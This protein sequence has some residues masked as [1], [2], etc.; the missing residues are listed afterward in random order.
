MQMRNKIKLSLI[1]GVI[2]L[3][4]ASLYIINNRNN[5]GELKKSV[6]VIY[7][8][9]FQT[10]FWKEVTKGID[11]AAEETGTE[12]VIVAA[13]SEGDVKGQ[14]ALVEEGIRS[15][16]SAILLAATDYNKLSSVVEEATDSDIPVIMIDSGVSTT[17]YVSYVGTDNYKAGYKVGQR[18]AKNLGVGD[19]VMIMNYIKGAQSA[20]E[21]EQGAIDGV[22]AYD[23][24]I[25]IDVYYCN[26]NVDDAYAYVTKMQDYGV[27]FHGYAGLNETSS[28][29]VGMALYDLGLSGTVEVI[30]IDSSIKEIELLENGTITAIVVQQPF[31]IGYTGIKTAVDVIMGKEVDKQIDTESKL[32]SKDEMY[33]PENRELLFPFQDN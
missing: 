6:W 22:R 11:L 30:C 21:R 16:P 23:K 27:T 8:S 33:L 1:I 15:N 29:G 2:L 7:K 20:M 10:E 28:T 17:D 25:G 26:D 5:D 18:L 13:S 24:Q 9:E 4:I 31:N 32:I 12:Y 19:R 14:I 3:L